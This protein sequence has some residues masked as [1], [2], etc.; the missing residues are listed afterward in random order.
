VE[1]YLFIGAGDENPGLGFALAQ[2][3]QVLS[4][5]TTLPALDF[6]LCG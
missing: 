6:L 3:R 1:D 2:T 5:L 4:H